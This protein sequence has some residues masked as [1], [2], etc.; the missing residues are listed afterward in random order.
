MSAQGLLAVALEVFVEK[1]GCG[2]KV[3]CRF[4]QNNSFFPPFALLK[5]ILIDLIHFYYAVGL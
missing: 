4:P 5:P 2:S 3:S 1:L